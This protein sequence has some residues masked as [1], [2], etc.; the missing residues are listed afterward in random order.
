MARLKG[1]L[2]GRWGFVLTLA[3]AA[4]VCL[5]Y[6]HRIYVQNLGLKVFDQRGDKVLVIS[7]ADFDQV[8]REMAAVVWTNAKRHPELNDIRFPIY[9]KRQSV[10][11]QFGQEP[12]MDIFLGNVFLPAE[13]IEAFR[14]RPSL[15]E[16][17][18]RWP[19]FY[20]DWEWVYSRGIVHLARESVSTPVFPRGRDYSVSLNWVLFNMLGQD[21]PSFR[22]VQTFGPG[23]ADDRHLVRVDQSLVQSSPSGPVGACPARPSG[24]MV[25]GFKFERPLGRARLR[26]IHTAWDQNEGLSL[27]A[28]ADG[29][30]WRPVYSDFGGHRQR[31]LG[32]ELDRELMGARQLF[33]KYR[34]EI[35][36]ASHRSPDDVRGA[37]LSF[38]DLSLWWAD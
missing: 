16:A 28:S 34:F 30:K 32:L 12:E 17:L 29:Q 14:Q 8:N 19:A 10:V 2:E 31:L 36:G 25:L 33:L 23:W 7:P 6:Y 38:F 37:N 18:D 9:V 4:G 1:F 27:W 35:K 22:H 3:V 24:E 21:R 15:E 26:D 20:L 13:E 5:S 11:D